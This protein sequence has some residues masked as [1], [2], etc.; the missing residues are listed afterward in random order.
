MQRTVKVKESGLVKFSEK[1]SN[2]SHRWVPSAMVFVLMLTIIVA[3]LALIICK[4]PFFSSTETQTSIVD[5]WVKGFWKLLQFAMQMALVMVTG[6]VVASS[7]PIKKGITRLAAFPNNQVSAIIFVSIVT[8]VI[9]W[10]HW[11]FGM[12]AG[13]LLGREILAQAR[14]KGY[15]IHK[16]AF[17]GMTYVIT[18]SSAGISIAAP[19]F[20]AS[21][22]FLKSLVSEESAALLPDALTL[23]Q[24]VLLPEVLTQVLVLGI[25]A[26]IVTLAMTPKN[27]DKIVEISDEFRDE[28][29]SAG[30]STKPTELTPAEK[31]NNNPALNIIVGGM[32]MYWAV[33][34]LINQGIVGM[35]IDNYN[36]LMLMLG[37]IL[38]WTPARFG[39]IVKEACGAIWGVVI[40]FPFYAG[41][42]GIIAYTGLNHVIANAFVSISTAHT[43]PWIAYLYSSILNFFVP[44][45]GS[46]F[47][48]EAPYIIPAAQQI[49]ADLASTLNAYSYGD[50]TTNLIQPFWA[51]PIL[52]MYKLEFKDILPYGFVVCVLA[53]IIN[54]GWMLL[55]Y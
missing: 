39:N 32:G 28:I 36:F 53:L 31:I 29:L 51:L 14:V 48:I 34:M 8:F 42:F 15:K 12:M 55:F 18:C 40:Q 13:I 21:P 47:I 7:P 37:V 38:C 9:W 35:S 11:G 10:I 23:N 46:K 49:G 17:V 20:A 2:W 16:S 50:L 44:S 30:K 45:G 19:L 24:T 4:V 22:G 52:A 54:S 26:T 3:A 27:E 25:M 43:F 5:A 33:K 41:I 1:F 6:F